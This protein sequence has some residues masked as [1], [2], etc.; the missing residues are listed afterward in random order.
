M[1]TFNINQRA[2]LIALLSNPTVKHPT[3][4]LGHEASILRNELFLTEEEKTELEYSLK[5]TPDGVREFVNPEKA[6]SMTKD[7]EVSSELAVSLAD[8]YK[9]VYSEG[10]STQ[11]SEVVFPVIEKLS[12]VNPD[13]DLTK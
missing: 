5:E 6:V 4:Q 10:F 7:F 11:E 3:L 9:K 13:K 8:S 1:I 2:S 12:E